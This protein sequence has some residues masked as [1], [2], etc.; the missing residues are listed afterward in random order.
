MK[1]QFRLFVLLVL[2][3]WLA[4]PAS[5]ASLQAAIDADYPYLDALFKQF[6]AQPELSMQ[7]FET[8]DRL[9]AELENAGFSITRN[10]GKTGLV[11]TMHNGDGP[12][13]LIRADMDGLPVLEKTGLDYA[14]SARQV[15]LEGDEMPVMH[16]CGH[17][18]HMTTLVGVAR[19]MAELKDQ[20][21]GT[22]LLLGQP[23]EES[24][25]GAIAMVADDLYGRVGRPDHALALHV[26]AKY[27]AG[28]IAF[29][30]GLMYSA[31]DTVRINV[32]GVA[33]H[34]ASP[35]LGKDPILLGSQIVV[36]LQSIITR[37]ISP[38]EPALITVGAFRGGSAPNIIADHAQ[39]DITVR[40]NTEETRHFLLESIARVATQTA[41]AAGV[42]EDRLPVIEIAASGSPTTTN[43]AALAQRVRAAMKAGMDEDAFVLWYQSDM[44]AEDFPDLVN[45]D[46]P[47]P[48]V[49]FEVGGTPPEILAAGTWADHHSPLFKI[50]AEASITAGVEAMTLAALDL[51]AKP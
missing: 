29:S 21:R 35:H 44:G 34:G 51:L 6:H 1:I 45:V 47:I 40:S 3:A 46:P 36:A 20:W 27:P 18:M 13:L 5:A 30:D 14:S 43:T 31:V 4:G 23:A 22:L 24:I 49:Y 11:G 10:I 42:P 28:K 41:R 17:D 50:D 16:A 7:E 37:E 32:R 15:N 26:I 19:R 9:A 25:G 12:V 38:L 39:L 33:T 8:S 2:S 48:S